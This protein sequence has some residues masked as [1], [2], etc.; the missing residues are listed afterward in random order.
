M[1]S[2]PPSMRKNT[3]VRPGILTLAVATSGWAAARWLGCGGEA[4]WLLFP[5]WVALGA[6][7]GVVHFPA[8]PA[9][10]ARAQWA[11]RAVL[12][13]LPTGIYLAMMT[14]L[15]GRFDAGEWMLA[16][17]FF[18]FSLE[19]VL[20]YVF[21]AGELLAERSARG[22]SRAAAAAL[23]IGAKISVYALIV[24]LLFSAF[25]LHRIKIPPGPIDPELELVAEEVSFPSRGPE[26][27]RLVG[28]FFPATGR[29]GA[30]PRGTI[31]ACHGVAANRADLLGIVWLLHGEG[32]QVLTFDFRGHGESDGHT[33]TYGFEEQKDVQGAYDFLLSRSDVDPERL[34]ALGVSMGA[35]SLLQ[36]LPAMEKVRAAVCDSAFVDLESMVRHQYRVLPGP[37]VT[38]LA[39][40]TG[41]FGWLET[42]IHFRDVSPLRALESIHVPILFFHGAEDRV[43]PAEH[44]RRLHAA[45]AGPKLLRIEEE[46]GH[47][48][49]SL[50]NPTRYGFEVAKFFD[51]AAR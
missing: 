32:F 47:G 29:D 12:V 36:A 6:A 26:P 24:P 5:A 41:F 39:E 1:G 15:R 38:I 35:A 37:A 23:R 20:L 3:L 9:R 11:V 46:A 34:F 50:A 19:F 49:A 16:V 8:Q 44:S 17:Y 42:G 48:G 14:L 22:R 33:V 2:V 28:S 27:R 4:F 21:R 45:Y 25:G 31:L 7:L 13:L 43:V 40:L 10:S 18:A 30:P 51:R